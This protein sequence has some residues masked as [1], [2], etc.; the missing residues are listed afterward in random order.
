MVQVNELLSWLETGCFD[1]LEKQYLKTMELGIYMD[2]SQPR[3]LIES[4]EFHFSYPGKDQYCFTMHQAIVENGK[5]TR[6]EITKATAQM[7][8]RL[9]T[10]TE[11]LDPLPDGAYLTMRLEYYDSAPN[12]KYKLCY[13]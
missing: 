12:G 9:L 5:L 2:P 1:A 6:K 8:R 3:Q 4:Y 13:R 7:V 11:T 10:L